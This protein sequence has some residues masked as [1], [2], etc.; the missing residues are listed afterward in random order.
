MKLLTGILA[1]TLTSVVAIASANAADMYVPGPG[2]YKD[3]PAYA[4]VNWSGFYI[5]AQLAALGLRTK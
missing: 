1:A 3:G 5:G 2:G 4:E